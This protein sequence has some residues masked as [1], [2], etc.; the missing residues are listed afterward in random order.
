[1]TTPPYAPRFEVRLSGVT[2]AADLAGQVLSLTVETDLDL[3]G[4]FRLTLRNPDNRL[5]DSALLD[6]GKTVEIHLG[7]GHELVPAFLGEVA[8]IEPSFPADEAPTV[9]VSGYDKSYRMRH[10]QTGP[11]QWPLI[12]DSIIAAEIA[13]EY[14]LIPIV[15]PAPYIGKRTKAEN[16]MAFLKSCADRYFFDVYVEW[17]RLHFHFPRPQLAAHVLE[18]GKNLSSFS[19]RISAAGLAGVQEIQVYNQELAQAIT[20]TMLADLDPETIT[21][22][23]GQSAMQ[24]LMS[25]VRKGV[26]KEP[27]ENPVQAAQL[28]LSILRNLLEGMYE[29]SG[30]CIG[31]PDL[32]AGRYVE[33]A[34]IGKRFSGTY[35]LRKVT[36]RIDGNGYRTDFSITSRGHTNLLGMLRKKLNEEPSPNQAER[37]YGVVL[38]EVE[39][40]N[41]LLAEVPAPPTGRV[42]VK[43]PGMSGNALS[44]WAP[45]VRPM[46]GDGT[47]FWALPAVGDQVLVAFLGGDVSKPY[48]LGALWTAKRPPPTTNAD[49]L[50]STRMLTTPS[51]HEIT[52]DDS[53]GLGSLTIS[54]AGDLSI[55][56]TG[57]IKLEAGLTKIEMT[58]TGVDV[59]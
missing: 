18:W 29:G 35:R 48:V 49:G 36:H 16:D 55:K 6:L 52:F 2:M 27:I 57:N 12:N 22:R 42:K 7:Y 37:F 50:N 59:T 47:G 38:G 1:M 20:V 30:S 34:G 28:G 51:G 3:A 25:F 4:S 46:A 15:D 11:A 8:S 45:M 14:G 41:E 21:E 9:V 10:S 5:L 56:A 32:T 54:A 19:P 24:L 33:I 26:S 58:P 39:A 44:D 40:N 13:A 31:I 43:Y 17:D 23:L 53:L